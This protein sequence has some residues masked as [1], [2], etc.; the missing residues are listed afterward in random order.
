MMV[1]REK[2]IKGLELCRDGRCHSGC[3]YNHINVGCRKH[4]DTDAIDLLKEKEP[5]S[6][7]QER[8]C[9]VE[10]TVWERKGYCPKC[11]QTV[12][13]SVNRLFCGFCGQKVKWNE[14]P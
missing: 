14:N 1:D 11:H 8:Q 7:I 5:K 4:L 9:E 12:L 3:P 2:V 10:P 6:V 13:W